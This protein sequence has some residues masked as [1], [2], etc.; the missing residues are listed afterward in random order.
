MSIFGVRRIILTTFD[1]QMTI[2]TSFGVHAVISLSIFDTITT[3]M[4]VFGANTVKMVIVG[5]NIVNI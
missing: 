4:T 3:I 1:T 5:G 2:L